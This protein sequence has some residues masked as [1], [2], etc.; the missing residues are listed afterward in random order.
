MANEI[1][2]CLHHLRHNQYQN[3]IESS[4]EDTA[5]DRLNPTLLLPNQHSK[6]M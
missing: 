2:Q 5:M 6:F 1:R 4:D 3:Q